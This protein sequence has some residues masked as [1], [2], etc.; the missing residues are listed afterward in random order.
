MSDSITQVKS[1]QGLLYLLLGLAGWIALI[2]GI[3]SG[4]EA[5]G[6]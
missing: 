5:S 1:T 3:A 6:E 2:V 4:H